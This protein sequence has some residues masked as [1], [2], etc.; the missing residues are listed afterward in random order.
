MNNISVCYL[1]SSIPSITTTRYNG[2]QIELI[3]HCPKLAQY[4]SSKNVSG[5]IPMAHYPIIRIARSTFHSLYC[6]ADLFNLTP[7]QLKTIS[8]SLETIC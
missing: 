5:E 1:V 4:T 6:V 8:A 7:S 2:R 3:L